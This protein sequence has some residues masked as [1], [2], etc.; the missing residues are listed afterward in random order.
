M[1]ES[2]NPK[3][4]GTVARV[5]LLGLLFQLFVVFLAADCAPGD[6]GGIPTATPTTT[7]TLVAGPQVRIEQ[8]GASA[9]VTV[10]FAATFE[11]R[12]L[13]LMHR[14]EMAEDAGMLFIF[15]ND[16]R[17]GF[18]MRNTNIPLDIAYIGAD[19]RV[20]EIRAAKPLD[21]TV[22]TPAAPYRYVLE[23]NQGW[24]QRH[25]LGVGAR[26]TLPEGLP[27]AQ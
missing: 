23:V 18:W 7:P 24:F 12:Q 10:E 1:T 25:N 5:W 6:D 4:R 21:E 14:T 16:V 27:T 17:T 20:Q 2:S 19:G 11:Q 9:S 8:N 22:L 3:Q 13:G 26:V 15:P